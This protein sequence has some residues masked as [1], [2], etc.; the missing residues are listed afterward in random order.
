MGGLII[1]LD[2][3]I[4]AVKEHSFEGLVVILYLFYN[5]AEYIETYRHWPETTIFIFS[6]SIFLLFLLFFNDLKSKLNKNIALLLT[7]G[8]IFSGGLAFI[9][10]WV[11]HERFAEVDNPYFFKFIWEYLK[12]VVVVIGFLAL[13]SF[14]FES[15]KCRIDQFR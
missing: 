7:V 1:L 15:I 12:Y 11:L 5:P 3:I 6:F 13:G 9:G 14:A 10:A 2:K 4:A 8:F